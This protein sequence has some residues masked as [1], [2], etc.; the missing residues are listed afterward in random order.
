MNDF[1]LVIQDLAKESGLPLEIDK[2]NSVTLE[3][4]DILVTLQWRQDV[5]DIFIFATI[6]DPNNFSLQSESVRDMLPP[7]NRSGGFLL[8]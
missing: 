3:Y 5:N 1:E 6:S 4:E 8:D 7:L 2:K